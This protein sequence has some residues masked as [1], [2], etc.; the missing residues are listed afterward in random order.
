MFHGSTTKGN[1]E[2]DPHHQL[3]IC[4]QALLNIA[5]VRIGPFSSFLVKNKRRLKMIY[6]WKLQCVKLPLQIDYSFS[7]QYSNKQMLYGLKKD[8]SDKQQGKQLLDTN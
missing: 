2:N 1:L 6:F 3:E 8:Y 7:Q 4:Q 5:H